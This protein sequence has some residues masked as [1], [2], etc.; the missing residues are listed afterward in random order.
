MSTGYSPYQLD[1]GQDPVFPANLVV[2]DGDTAI[3][4]NNGDSNAAVES[5]LAD[6]RRALTDARD[7]LVK[8]Q[9]RQ[10]KYADEGR[11]DE[12]FVV[13]DRVMLDTSDLHYAKGSKKLHLKYAGPYKVLKVV[14]SVSYQIELPVSWRIHDVFHVS[15]LKRA[16]ETDRFPTREQQIN[17]PEP[18]AQIDGEDAW[19]VEQIVDKRKHRGRVQYLVKWVGYPDH[20]NT[21]LPLSNLRQA[22]DAIDEYEQ[23]R[24]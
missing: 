6:M 3:I 8:A 14:S 18:E 1:L 17:R 11:R 5:M 9:Q 20:E 7:N 21:W 12:S 2:A 15:K 23:S 22:K 13:G 16:I 19:E 24:Q 4:N 10:K